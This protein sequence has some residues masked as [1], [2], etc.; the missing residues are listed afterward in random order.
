MRSVNEEEED[1]DAED[2]PLSD[3]ATEALVSSTRTKRERGE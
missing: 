3:L 2:L 1:N